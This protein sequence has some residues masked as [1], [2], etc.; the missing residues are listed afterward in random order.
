M[1]RI[2]LL[3]GDKKRK[4]GHKMPAIFAAGAGR[5]VLLYVGIVAIGLLANG[6]YFWKLGHD[7]ARIE[8][9]TAQAENENRRLSQ[10]KQR[11]L[12]AEKQ[13]TEY[14]RRVDLI[15]QLRTNQTGPV[16]LLTM[17][18]DT[19]N[20]TDAVWLSAMKE[21]ETSV[22]IEGM[23]LSP[24]AVANLMKNLEKTGYFKAVEIKETF[25]DDKVTNIQ[26]FQFTLNCEKAQGG[27]VPNEKAPNDKAQKS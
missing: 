16:N 23:A 26:A 19:V 11:Y 13:K 9:D 4:G 21:D 17:I 2:N 6:G 27:K 7:K 24:T 20:Q 8:R 14:K 5:P 3:G 12:E 15:E 10:V 25:Q 18:G 22:H 1:I